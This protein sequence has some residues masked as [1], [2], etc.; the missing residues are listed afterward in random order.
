MYMRQAARW[1]DPR[2]TLAPVDATHPP[3]MGLLIGFFL[4]RDPSLQGLVL[5]QLLVSCLVPLAVGAL[6]LAV[7]GPGSALA[8]IA[9]ASLYFPFIDYGGYFLSEIYLALLAPLS[10]ACFLWAN[11]ARRSTASALLGGLAA[12]LSFSLA[13]SMKVVALA[14]I[15]LFCAVFFVFHRGTPWRIKGLAAAGM[16]LGALP[17]VTAISYRASAATGRYVLA[18]NKSGADFLLGH[19]GRIRLI[20]WVDPAGPT[21]FFGSPSAPQR[22]YDAERTLPFAVHDPVRNRALAWSWIRAH[23]AEAVVLS[24]EHVY[25]TLLGTRCWPSYYENWGKSVVEVFH[26]LYV[27]LVL[28]P[29]L[30]VCVDAARRDGL[31]GFLGSPELLLLTPILGVLVAVFLS[32]GEARYRIPFD[33]ALLIL[34][35]A[36]LH[37]TPPVGVYS[38]R[39]TGR[40]EA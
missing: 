25:D 27:G 40:T 3:G 31:R 9:A 39:G 1:I 15:G 2:Y 14:A 11:G 12:G 34:A 19:Y 30:L 5:F 8:A 33:G 18:S 35:L 13:W 20:R 23:P 10:L 28:F 16:I 36:C 22:G 24:L 7:F 4:E 21:L 38:P 6:A 26:M 29:A 32:T 17:L 37:R